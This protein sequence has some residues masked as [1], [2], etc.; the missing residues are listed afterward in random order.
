MAD[1]T[2]GRPEAEAGELPAFC[3]VCAAPAASFQR[4]RFSWCTPGLAVLSLGIL[5]LTGLRRAYVRVP[6]CAAHRHYWRPPGWRKHSFRVIFVLAFAIACLCAM[7]W[8]QDARGFAFL[9]AG[10][11]LLWLVVRT[12]GRMHMVSAKEITDDSI[13]LGGVAPGFEKKLL[14]ER[15]AVARHLLGMRS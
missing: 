12:L 8:S 2:L 1:V 7:A 6:L 15:Q 3:M 5:V 13:T 4:Q 14:E 11:F 10:F 9:V